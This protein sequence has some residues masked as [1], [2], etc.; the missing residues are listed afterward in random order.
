MEQVDLGG[1]IE[2]DSRLLMARS[3]KN[4][5]T[6]ILTDLNITDKF[7]Y[8]YLSSHAKQCSSIGNYV[9]DSPKNIGMAIGVK[10][11]SV[12]NSLKKLEEIGLVV[13]SKTSRKCNLTTYNVFALNDFKMYTQKSLKI[14]DK[15][16]NVDGIEIVFECN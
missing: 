5:T 13:K 2:I 16:G 6:E 10:I 12:C 15:D 8:S 7:I 11:K 4:S 9:D 1:Y 14:R 3:I